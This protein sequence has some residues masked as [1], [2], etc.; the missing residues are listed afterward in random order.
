MQCLRQLVI[1][2]TEG[3]YLKSIIYVILTFSIVFKNEN[4]WISWF[5]KISSLKLYT[6]LQKPS[7]VWAVQF[8]NSPMMA[9]FINVKKSFLW[10]FNED[11]NN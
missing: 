6:S 1:S 2:W 9:I 5:I 8:Q 3:I 10:Q 4:L 7:L 11:K